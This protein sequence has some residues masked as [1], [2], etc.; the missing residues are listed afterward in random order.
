MKKTGGTEE[1][2]KHE[3]KRKETDLGVMKW[4]LLSFSIWRSED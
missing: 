3:R 4:T 2:K 1:E